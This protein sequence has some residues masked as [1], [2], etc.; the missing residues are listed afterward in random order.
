MFPAEFFVGGEK[1][2][3]SLSIALLR[4]W[5]CPTLFCGRCWRGQTYPV[6]TLGT[7]IM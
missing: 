4:K 6:F 7:D 5:G 2:H 1:W 3:F